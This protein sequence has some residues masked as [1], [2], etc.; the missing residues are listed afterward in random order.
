M[1]KTII[2]VTVIAVLAAGGYFA[3]HKNNKAN[4]QATPSNTAANQ[5]STSA[6]PTAAATITYDGSKFSPSTITVKSGDTVAIKNSSSADM[7]FQSN[8]HPLHTDDTDLNV[9]VVPA[10]QTATFKATK[11][12]TFG[13]H[14]HLSPDQGGTITIQ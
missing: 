8:P 4:S 9:G 10:G 1:I 13:Y 2:I 14:N 11:T 3:F 6:N 5:S 12:G 7:Q